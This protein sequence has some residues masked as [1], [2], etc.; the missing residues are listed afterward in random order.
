MS[1]VIVLVG[2]MG[3]GKSACGRELAGRLGVDFV[4][5]DDFIER[6]TAQT[7]EEIFST[8]GEDAFRRMEENAI[9]HLLRVHTGVLALGGGAVESRR[10]RVALRGHDVAWLQVDAD[11]AVARIG[12]EHTRPLLN[13]LDPHATW[14]DLAR[15]REPFF[16]EAVTRRVETSGRSVPA[17]VAELADSVRSGREQR[18]EQMASTVSATAAGAMEDAVAHAFAGRRAVVRVG[19]ANPYD[20]VIGRNL[21]D[22]VARAVP[23]SAGRVLI[24][25]QGA[26]RE[27]AD[28]IRGRLQALGKEAFVAEIPDGEEA[29]TAQVLAFLWQVCGQAG[30]TRNDCIVGVGG[31]AAT[32]LA[33]FAAATWLRGV[34]VIH[35][36]TTVAGMVDAAVGGKTG[37]NTAEGKNLVGAF[38][39]PRAVIADLEALDSLPEFDVAAGLAEVVKAGLVA[40]SVI[41]EIIETDP[42]AALAVSSPEFA[43][44]M[45]RAIAVKAEVVSDDLTEKGKREFLN[46]GHTFGHAIERHERYQWR[47]GAAVSVGMVYAAELACLAGYMDEA[48]VERHRAILTSLGLPVSYRGGQWEQLLEA[49]K[50]DKK[51]RGAVLRFVVLNGVGRPTR[52]EGPD[53]ALLTAAYAAVS[54]EER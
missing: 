40:D 20:V 51:T 2:P 14:A 39:P 7:I 13:V 5:S 21:I 37:I 1:P 49:M 46:Y 29:K 3:A 22:D 36:P 24:V 12:R 41:V 27:R 9:E 35:A 30:L 23:E 11:G 6:V 44:L 26:V 47:H 45:V 28:I 42:R 48:D 34:D 19:G 16:E 52:L 4:D 31:G 32:D 25:H 43:E 38:Y 33:G 54:D 53:P 8:R 50:R 10:T 18:Q 17:V 15:R